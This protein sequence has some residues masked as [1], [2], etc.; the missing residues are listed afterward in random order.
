LA[1]CGPEID[2]PPIEGLVALTPTISRRPVSFDLI[3][4][5]T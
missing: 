4:E 3:K 2:K 1:A 5:S